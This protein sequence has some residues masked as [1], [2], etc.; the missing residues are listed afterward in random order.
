M[1]T[2]FFRGFCAPAPVGLLPGT[3]RPAAAAFPRSL[4]LGPPE[5]KAP[6]DPDE[7]L[8]ELESLLPLEEDPEELLLSELSEDELLS[9]EEDE[10]LSD[11]L[12]LSLEEEPDDEEPLELPDDP[13]E[14]DPDELSL[15]PLELPDEPELPRELGKG[16]GLSGGAFDMPTTLPTFEESRTR[17]GPMRRM[18]KTKSKTGEDGLS[19]YYGRK[20]TLAEAKDLNEKQARLGLVGASRADLVERISMLQ[21]V[22]ANRRR[23]IKKQRRAIRRGRKLAKCLFEDLLSAAFD[24]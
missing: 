17:A 1:P 16:A 6:L 22:V 15:D 10:E 24:L 12:L 5:P 14:E 18:T 11:E 4:L 8:P 13:D 9:L 3:G 20:V 19:L 21:V 2:H 23:H 7:E